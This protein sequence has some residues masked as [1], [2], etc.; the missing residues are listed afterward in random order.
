MICESCRDAIHLCVDGPGIENRAGRWCDCQ[1]R[2]GKWVPDREWDRDH[3]RRLSQAAALMADALSGAAL[4]GISLR[5]A[6]EHGA[7]L[8]AVREFEQDR[9]PL[10]AFPDLFEGVG[11]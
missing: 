6:L 5:E 11:A 7:N 8:Y 10:V 1:H 4:Y 2:D 3:E 9:D